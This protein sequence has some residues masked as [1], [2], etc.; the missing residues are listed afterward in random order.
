MHT[1]ALPH[2]VHSL[3]RPGRQFSLPVC[4]PAQDTHKLQLQPTCC[5]VLRCSDWKARLGGHR[6]N[7]LVWELHRRGLVRAENRAAATGQ[8]NLF[9]TNLRC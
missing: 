3:G 9:F 6:L 5:P 2:L 4:H 8:I 7:S 1:V